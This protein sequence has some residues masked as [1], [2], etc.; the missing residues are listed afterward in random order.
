MRSRFSSVRQGGPSGQTSAVRTPCLLCAIIP[1]PDPRC[2]GCDRDV[3]VSPAL[4]CDVFG[5]RCAARAPIRL[6]RSNPHDVRTEFSFCA[7]SFRFVLLSWAVSQGNGHQACRER[8]RR[9]HA[10]Q[11]HG[12]PRLRPG[13]ISH[14][15]HRRGAEDP[16]LHH[17]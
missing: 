9:D 1:P 3:M 12:V 2:G 8:D 16:P 10:G 13:R 7:S 4:R 14:A 6:L 17:P 15:W 11:G 5:S